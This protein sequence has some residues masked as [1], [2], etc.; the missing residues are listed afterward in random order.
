MFEQTLLEAHFNLIPFPVYVSDLD[1]YTILFASDILLFTHGELRG[2]ICYK[3]LHGTT[4]P[5]D[6]CPKKHILTETGKPN[7]KV[8]DFEYFNEM[9]DCWYQVKS[10]ALGWSDGSIVQQSVRVDIT[11]LKEAQSELAEAHATMALH[12]KKLEHVSATDRLT[13]LANRLR[14]DEVMA[15]ACKKAAKNKTPL[16]IAILDID[17]FK[18]VNDTYGHQTGD[19][20]LQQLSGILKDG[21]RGADTPGRWGGEEFLIIMP[22]LAL[23][24]AIYQADTLRQKIE[25]H[26]FPEVGQKTASFGVAQLDTDESI[27]SLI[28]RAD[29][30]LYRAKETGRNRVICN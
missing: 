13:G 27:A 24:D 28:K 15:K 1:T 25:N 26:D 10:R 17:H 22:G 29:D 20:V 9:E 6:F 23:D 5:C 2:K 7:G 11:E 18:S 4:K 16:S 19:V 3:A 12:N 14:L 21:V 8:H 30:A